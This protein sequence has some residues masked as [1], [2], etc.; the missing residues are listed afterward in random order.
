M[1]EYLKGLYNIY[2]VLEERVSFVF[3]LIVAYESR[4]RSLHLIVLKVVL[5]T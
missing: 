3:L 4:Q 5:Q 1:K 2:C